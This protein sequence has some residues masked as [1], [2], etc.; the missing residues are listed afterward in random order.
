M[1]RCSAQSKRLTIELVT[2]RGALVAPEISHVVWR[3][4]ADQL[5]YIRKQGEG[6]EASSILYL[7]DV[8]SAHE[9]VLLK[10]QGETASLELDSCQWSPRG[11]ALL[12]EGGNDLWLYDLEKKTLRRLTNDADAEENASFSPTGDKVAFVKK[13]DL[14]VLNIGSGTLERLTTDGSAT[15]LNGKLDWVYEEELADRATAPAFAWSPDGKKIAYLRLDDAPVP[16][17]PITSYLST[18]VQLTEQ[19]FPQSGD[20]NPLPSFRV[21]TVGEGKPQTW[22][23]SLPAG[24]EYLGP[25][26]SWAKDSRTICFLT[27]NR[28][29]DELNVHAWNPEAGSDRALVTEKDRFWINSLAAPY[30][31]N[32]G[33]RFLW[34]S[35]R[36]GWLHL[37]LYDDNG[38]LL[39]QVT[40]GAWMIDKPP[41]SDAPLFQ[42]DESAGWVYFAS[43]NPDPRDR[44]LFRVHLDGTGMERLSK[45]SGTHSLDLSPD[46]RYLVD[47]SSDVN[48][49]PVTRL[50]RANGDF[51]A[52]LDR[53]EN[54]LSEYGLGS[55]YFVDVKAPDGA[56]LDARMIQ[57]PDFDP[58][59]KY[60]VIVYV[61]GGPHIQ[62][63]RN[64]WSESNLF[65]LYMAQEGFLVWTLDNRGSWGRGHAWESVIFEHMGRQELADQVTGVQYLASLPYV[66]SKRI[67]IRG[68]S[69]GGYMT[70]YALTHAPEVFKCG[71]AGGPV[72]DWKFYDSIYTERYMRTATENPEGYAEASP[73]QAASHL[74]ARV[75]LIHGA[76]D[77]NVHM[78]NTMN[79]I[80]AL[81]KA[82][83]TF[84]LYIQPGQK[85]G[86]VG[87]A[88]RT[89]LN[90]RVF[91]F[92]RKNL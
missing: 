86:F 32:D 81:V 14:Y 67:G 68:W 28:H 35:E 83:H 74:K 82:G 19:R 55:I 34:L 64:A 9:S 13:N 40:R 65:D 3:P 20:Q 37:Y 4:G 57:P 69:Y 50:L 59:K 1:V 63:V 84:E 15:V 48:T 24:V 31:L 91:D 76:D 80:D 56:T 66:D 36:D 29:Q 39:R 79:F 17:Y 73:L 5:A 26:F 90:Q 61:Y 2:R 44:H 85:H 7:Y 92:F 42:V 51:V 25:N 89:Y 41:F 49:P 18:H 12:F 62:M 21:V 43:T 47:V 53:P 52:T 38:K 45:E 70:L 87:D 60:P 6:R 8:A 10:P 78:Q 54:H 30:F 22:T 58:E 75:L 33:H 72:T 11:D 77:D 27:L 16:Q 23:A 88:V 46:G 71:A